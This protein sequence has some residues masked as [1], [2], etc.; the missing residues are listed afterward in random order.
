MLPLLA[1]ATLAVRLS[2]QVCMAPCEVRAEVIIQP[3]ADNRY[4]VIQLD[5]PMFSSSAHELEG[6]K[7]AVIQAP[8]WF[9]GLIPGEYEVTAVLYRVNA[10]PSEVC[11]VVRTI[12]VQ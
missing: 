7:A 3:N 9:K 12:Q 1:A 2:T 5:G 11:R 4:W 10:K 8:V 6:D